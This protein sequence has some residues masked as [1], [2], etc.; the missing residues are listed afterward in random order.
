MRVRIRWQG[1]SVEATLDETPTACRIAEA[2]PCV[3]TANT[4]GDEVYF[5]LPVTATLDSAPQQVVE[6]GTICFWVQGSAL[7]IP[8]GRTPIA[9]GNECRLV[10]ACN[11]VGRVDGDPRRLGGI[12][13]GDQVTVESLE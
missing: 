10:T 7:A 8:Y 3:S 13:A 11:V 5:E 2:L 9:E 4:W 12:H 6:P 1:G